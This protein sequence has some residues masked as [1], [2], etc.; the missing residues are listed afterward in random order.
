MIT[1]D[2]YIKNKVTG[3]YEKTDGTVTPLTTEDL[4]DE[5]LDQAFIV[6]SNTQIEV[7]EPSTEVKAVIH[8]EGE[9][10]VE[11]YYIVGDDES[12][13]TPIGQGFYTHILSLIE[14]TKLLEGIV[15]QSLTFTDALEK[16]R[17]QESAIIRTVSGYDPTLGDD[18]IYGQVSKTIVDVIKEAFNY[19]SPVKRNETITLVSPRE[20]GR[21]I[22]KLMVNVATEDE[23]SAT[24]EYSI[25]GGD[26]VV[27]DNSNESVAASQFDFLNFTYK[28]SVVKSTGNGR[29]FVE[30]YYSI[31]SSAEWNT[32][33]TKPW[34]ITSGINRVLDLAEP[35]FLGDTPRFVLNP[36]QAKKWENTPL[37]N[38]TMT[39][40]TLREQL[41]H[42][43]NY[44]HSQARLGGYLTKNITYNGIT[45]NAGYYENMIFFDEYGQEEESTLQGKPYVSNQIRH[46]INEYNTQIDTTA[47]NIVNTLDYG[48]AVVFAP[49]SA[50]YRTIRAEGIN[51]RLQES[52]AT[53]TTEFPI[54][55]VISLKC[56]AYKPGSDEAIEVN[57]T[58]EFDITPY[59]FEQYA[60]GNL[61]SFGG[62]YPYSKSYA[63]YY[64]QGEKNINGLF[65]KPTTETS[66]IFGDYVA[67]YSIV[68]ILNA[69]APYF[70]DFDS[71]TNW[72]DYVTKN[73]PLLSFQIA[74]IPFY[75]SKY[76]HTD[77][78]IIGQDRKLPFAKI[79]NQSENVIEARFYGENIKGVAK[80]LGNQEATRTYYL[81][82]INDVAKV[83]TMLDGYYISQAVTEYMPYSIRCTVGLT[84]HFNRLSQNVGINSHKRVAEVSEREAYQ[85]NILLKEYICI[86]SNVELPL[87]P[88]VLQPNVY[89]TGQIF[90]GEDGNPIQNLYTVANLVYRNRPSN[91]LPLVSSVKAPLVSSAFG[92]CFTFSL[93]MKD[94]YSAGESLGWINETGAFWQ[95]D[96]AYGDIYGRAYYLDF[97]LLEKVPNG[98]LVQSALT[99]A[100]SPITVGGKIG[101]MYDSAKLFPYVLRKDSREIIS[102]NIAFEY[103]S[104][105]Q[106]LI[107]SSAL[108]SSNPLVSN[109]KKGV[110]PKIYYFADKISQ[111]ETD[112]QG[113][114]ALT[115]GDLSGVYSDNGKTCSLS[116]PTTT[117]T[118]NDTQYKSWCIAYPVTEETRTVYNEDTGKNEDVTIYAGGEILI[119]CNNSKDYYINNNKSFDYIYIKAYSDKYKDYESA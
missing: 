115:V 64:K 59:V 74:Y 116:I 93:T 75:Q 11:K 63:L 16:Y 83:G 62:G 91:D 82:S 33:A 22:Y 60:Y 14:R 72:K 86:G 5:A 69:V 2:F 43:G 85:R 55:Q 117:E 8:Q 87:K 109:S 56:K 6:L 102:L 29:D 119:A 105:R 96:V 98:N 10:D 114:T 111:Y 106:D 89:H 20:F 40:C 101:T 70:P 80:R 53:I 110:K 57:G 47:Q 7:I 94:N 113:K 49:D 4:L 41:Q 48:D 68:N 50:W 76:S 42:I 37:P 61:S 79:Y 19:V 92:N 99:C 78:Y 39:Q 15:C 1:F 26:F 35:L 12:T 23:M 100:I 36:I 103:I 51:L 31:I 97:Q 81:G 90:V 24:L 38:T 45:Y 30:F 118:L 73:F 71:Y 28:V 112:I 104:N 66:A 21:K 17:K 65:F 34:T 9:A 3:D 107:L 108:A 52:N 95:R 44:V 84:K 32:T 54:Y 58:S 25:N 27:L 18:E 88:S 13:E 67:N 77:G 46:S